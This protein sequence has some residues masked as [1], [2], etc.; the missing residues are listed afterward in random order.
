VQFAFAADEDLARA[1]LDVVDLDHDNLGSAKSQPC[2]EEQHRVVAAP[3]GVLGSDSPRLAAGSLR[4]EI[5][6]QMVGAG[7]GARQAVGEIALGFAAPE[8]ELEQAEQ[9]RRPCFVAAG[10]RSDFKL[11]Q[12]SDDIVRL[13]ALRSPSMSS[14]RNAMNRSRKR[15]Q[16]AIVDSASP[17]YRRR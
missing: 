10:L 13:I 12:E 17:R 6:R 2:H 9:M 7:G 15:V 1:P 4:V 14:K 3:D 11:A 16:R 8:Q 5:A